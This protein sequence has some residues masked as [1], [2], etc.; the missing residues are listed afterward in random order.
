MGN[1]EH[2]IERRAQFVTHF[3]QKLGPDPC[4]LFRFAPCG[5][6]L[7]LRFRDGGD[8]LPLSNDGNDLPFHH[9]R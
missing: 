8:I 7:L 1:T 9:D 4:R 2:T 5:L 3:G 6:A